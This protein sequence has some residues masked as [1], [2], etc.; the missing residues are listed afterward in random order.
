MSPETFEAA[1]ELAEEHRD[2]IAIGGGEPTLHPYFWQYLGMAL[3]TECESIWLATNGS[4][5]KTALRLAQ[6]ARR[7]IIGVALSLDAYH[8]TIDP[9]VQEAFTNGARSRRGSENDLR[10]IRNVGEKV[11][12]AGRAKDWGWEEDCVCDDLFVTP[13][14]ILKQCGCKRAPTLGTVF[15]PQLDEYEQG[16]YKENHAH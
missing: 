12:A 8:D 10:E 2:Y 3:G 6:L 9:L 1:L 16:C 15:D 5:T 13:Q 4:V 14:G 7:G 11:V